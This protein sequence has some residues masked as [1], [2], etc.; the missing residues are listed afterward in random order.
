MR[1]KKTSVLERVAT[2]IVDKR[3]LIFLMYILAII[4]CL[5]SMKWV[6]VENDITAYL[7]EDT[8]T[9]QGITVMDE[10]FVTFGT[11]RV[12][13]SNISYDHAQEIAGALEEVEGV[14]TVEFEQTPKHYK[15]ASALFDITLDG[16]EDDPISIQAMKDIREKVKAYDTYISTTVGV[17][18]ADQLASEMQVI[19][20][21]AAGIIL[22]VLLF[23]SKT[24][25]EIPVLIITF[26]VAAILNMGTNFLLGKISFI[27]HSVAVVLQLALAIDYAII[28]CHRF[29]EEHEE[30][31]TREACIVALSKAIPEIASSSLTT[32]SGLVA[33]VFMHFRIGGDL[34]TVLVKAI[35]LSLL[36]VF[37]L[38]PGLLMLFSKLIDKTPHKNFVP[39]INIVG[40]FVIKTRYIIPPIF[41][42]VLGVAFIFA[43]K[44]PYLYGT[45]DLRATRRNEVQIA[46]D[47]IKEVFGTDNM[48]ALIVPGGDYEAE[49][50][51]LA[52]LEQYDQVKSTLGLANTE[53]MDDYMLTDALSPRQFA[54]LIDL[55]YEVARLL[56]SAY[57]VHDEAF[58][59]V[60][61]GL[62]TY[63]VPLIDMFMFLYDEVDKGYITLEDELMENLEDLHNELTDAKLQLMSEDYSRMLVYL[64]LP[65]ES[66]ETFKFLDTIYDEASEY[67]DHGVYIVGNSTS[68]YDLSLTFGM[69]NIIISILSA[70]FVIIILMFTFKSAGLPILLIVVI[71]ASIWMNFS[72]PYLQNQGLFFLGY[73]VVSSIQ[74][75]ANIDYAIVIT[76]RYMELKK[77]MPIKEAI[78]EALNQSFPTIITSGTILAAAGILIGQ[79]TTDGTIASIGVCLGRG[80]IISIV[81][82]MFVLPQILVL[83]DSLIERTAFA[84]RPQLSLQKAN[85]KIQVS[86][87]VKGYVSGMIDAEFNGVIDGEIHAVVDSGEVRMQDALVNE[88]E[89]DWDEKH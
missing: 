87:K 40:K 31:Q 32:I 50:A 45:T 54:E 55:D 79:L 71:Q 28:L 77:A 14:K 73:L 24:Y 2:I 17:S 9:R 39:S 7:A 60:V 20:I 70:L 22:L 30:L 81:L 34:A 3:N 46:A 10:E 41:V 76:S 86:G 1:E 5:F 42:V 89:V 29:S 47:R 21:I 72:F 37:T 49:G 43:N 26:V 11:A 36:T 53:A 82:V 52:K 4:F 33:L 12:M 16:E 65:E 62:D 56:Y 78:I 15:N 75:G 66:E 6:E 63:T 44:C 23:T 58:G 74:M 48:V 59:K 8:K 38:M 13:I 85:G 61:S 83:G 18:V 64:D 25:G 84:K 27:S 19:I 68:N 88:K 80:T 51:L 35:L 69:D 57:A 67:Y